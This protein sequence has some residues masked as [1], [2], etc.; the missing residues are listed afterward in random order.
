[1]DRHCPITGSGYGCTATFATVAEGEIPGLKATSDLDDQSHVVHRAGYTIYPTRT[2]VSNVG[3]QKLLMIMKRKQRE[4]ASLDWWVEP[5]LKSVR[6]KLSDAEL[7]YLKQEF[8]LELRDQPATVL[9]EQELAR[10]RLKVVHPAAAPS[11]HSD[12]GDPLTCTFCGGTADSVAPL[13]LSPV[14]SCI[15]KACAAH[16]AKLFQ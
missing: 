9:S 1:M 14:G 11:S 6:N 16:C 10:Q 12:T 5:Y 2:D 7:A 3:T 8:G 4:S 13:V 15:C